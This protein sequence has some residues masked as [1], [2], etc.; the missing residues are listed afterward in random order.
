[1]GRLCR[2]DTSAKEMATTISSVFHD[3]LIMSLAIG[4][5]PI[6][7]IVDGMFSV[8]GLCQTFH[9]Y[10]SNY[11]QEDLT[12]LVNIMQVWFFNMLVWIIAKWLIMDY[13]WYCSTYFPDYHKVTQVEFYRLVK[14]DTS[15]SG[16]AYLDAIKR[17]LVRD[18]IW[19]L[20]K[21]NAVAIV[22]DAA[23]Y[24]PILTIIINNHQ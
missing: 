7:L 16:Q 5:S 14:L 11:F 4:N 17:D 18:N 24:L 9:W 21:K 19:E 1:M 12:I 6:T 13:V 15:S 23:R 3:Q 2:S 20:V 10:V 8:F 22:T